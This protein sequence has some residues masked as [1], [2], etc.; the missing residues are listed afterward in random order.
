[1]NVVFLDYDGVVNTPQW[2]CNTITGKW[3]CKFNYASDGMVNDV[4]AVQWVSEF[5]EKHGYAIV[6]TSTWRREKNY[7]EYLRNAGLRKGIKI[8]DHTT[9]AYMGSRGEE[10]NLWLEGHPEVEKY[11]IFDDDCD[12]SEE[13]MKHLVRCNSSVGFKMDEFNM[14]EKLHLHFLWA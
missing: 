7:A 9:R 12:F 3:E 13:Q 1:M 4:Q 6:V 8:I 14:A 5:C 10:I 2:S 11:L